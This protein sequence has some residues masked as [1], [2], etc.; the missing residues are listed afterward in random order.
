MVQNPGSPFILTTYAN[1]HQVDLVYNLAMDEYFLAFVVVHTLATTGNDIY[2]LRV[3]W[4]GAPVNPP[5]LIPIYNGQQPE[6]PGRR[7]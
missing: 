2:G 3:S 7:H 5:G 1:P 4:Y 6:R